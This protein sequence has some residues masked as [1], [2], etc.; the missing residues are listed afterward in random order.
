[1]GRLSGAVGGPAPAQDHLNREGRDRVFVRSANGRTADWFRAALAAGAAR[2]AAGDTTYDVVFAETEVVD[3]AG[4]D[5]AYDAKYGR[6]SPRSSNTCSRPVREAPPLTCTL[7]ES[8][9]ARGVL[10]AG[11][12]NRTRTF[13]L[14]S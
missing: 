1:V 8:D 10:G 11:D 14:G 12:E 2:I 7:P 5:V 9:A 3:L 4:V 6:Y 13:S